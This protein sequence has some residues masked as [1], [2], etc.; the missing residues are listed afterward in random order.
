MMM[1]NHLRCSLSTAALPYTRQR[2][3]DERAHIVL[4]RG[5]S[6]VT[7]NTMRDW[8]ISHKR[9]ICRCMLLRYWHYE[10]VGMSNFNKESII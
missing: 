5:H 7:T 8:I 9:Y 3:V 1:R 10:G 6:S 4:I 2:C